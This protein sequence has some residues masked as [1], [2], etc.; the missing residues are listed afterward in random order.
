MA[1]LNEN[2]LAKSIAEQEGGKTQVNIAQIKEC[3]K[4]TLDI[5]AKEVPSVALALIEKHNG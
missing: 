1:K 5:L 3:L 4:I 2:K